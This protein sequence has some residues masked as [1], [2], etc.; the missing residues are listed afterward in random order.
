MAEDEEHG[1]HEYYP[2][3]NDDDGETGVDGATAEMSAAT[4]SMTGPPSTPMKMS[5]ETTTTQAGTV[6]STTP[7]TTRI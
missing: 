4:R 3:G 6:T 5:T 7:E 1:R 2:N